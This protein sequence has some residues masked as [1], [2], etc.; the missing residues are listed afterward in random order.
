ML[1]EGPHK[2][3]NTSKERL[4][5]VHPDLQDVF[6]VVIQYV[7]CT[8]LSGHRG[9]QEQNLAFYSEPQR[10]KVKWPNSNHNKKPS[11]AIDAMPW[12]PGIGIDW[13]D[14]ERIT[15]FARFVQGVGAGMGIKIRWG[16]DWNSDL[17]TS[18][19]R[20]LDGPHFELIK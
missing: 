17:R 9:E 3:G 10:S 1:Y 19:E 20:F 8:I 13:E 6:N 7:D 4:S 11:L 12:L 2:W 14:W 18:D 5:S 15:S 16:A